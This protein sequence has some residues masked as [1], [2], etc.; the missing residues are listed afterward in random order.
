MAGYAADYL[1]HCFYCNAINLIDGI[2][3]LASGLSGV[4]LMVL[5]VLFLY[6]QMWTY[7][8]LAF[9]NIGSVDPFSFYYNVFGQVEHGRKIFMG[10][11]GAYTIGLLLSAMSIRICHIEHCPVVIIQL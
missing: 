1:R 10:D 11:T 2:D 3:G 9:L 6:N 7:A 8:T 4:S 5:G